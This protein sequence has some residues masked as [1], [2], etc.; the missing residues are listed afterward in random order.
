MK[1][2][3]KLQNKKE[4]AKQQEKVSRGSYC[5]HTK[6]NTQ[7]TTKRQTVTSKDPVFL[8]KKRED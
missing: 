5:F 8:G 7:L 4:N 6:S 3:S 1:K 2:N